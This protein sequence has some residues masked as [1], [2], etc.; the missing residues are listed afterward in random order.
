MKFIPSTLFVLLSRGVKVYGENPV[1]TSD[2]FVQSG[3]VSESTAIIMV[4][5][6]NEKDSVVSITIDGGAS[7]EDTQVYGARD[8]TTSV[9]V[10]GLESNTKYVYSA[11]CTPLDG[12]KA[13]YSGGASFKTA[14]STDDDGPVSFVWA[15]DL[16]GQGWGRNP[17]F[18]V[19][20]VNGSVSYLCQLM[21]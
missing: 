19:T 6:S 20:T 17:D 1:T 9:H 12:S 18:E 15:A 2:V 21:F 7:I 4:R 13:I 11:K 14:P 16:A 5:C 3:E 10:E 8:Y